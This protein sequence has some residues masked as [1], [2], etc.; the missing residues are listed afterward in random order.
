MK[1]Y[2]SSIRILTVIICCLLLSNFNALA[3]KTSVWI[4]MHAE[5]GKQD[6]L[7][8]AGQA[9]AEELAKI[10]K[11]EKLQAIYIDE[12]K[13]AQQTADVLG[14]K[15]KI[16]PRVYADSI[17]ALADKIK[18]NFVGNKVL[19]V[20]KYNNVIPLLSALGAASPFSG[21]AANDNDLMFTVTLNA[22]SGKVDLFI[23]HYGK[24]Q[25]STEI[26]QQY[27]LESFYP[28]FVPPTNSH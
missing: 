1:R 27:I 17:K 12:T 25:H 19:V 24:K 14:Q 4:V 13:A 23:S 22:N 5:T 18:K 16:L 21:V 7:N 6:V 11:R 8:S 15:A 26:P 28:S 2:V 10:L 3:Q 20:A 9:R